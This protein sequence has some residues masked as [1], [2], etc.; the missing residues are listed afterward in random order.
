MLVPTSLTQ[1]QPLQNPLPPRD[2]VSPAV[3]VGNSMRNQSGMRR[4]SK[5][6]S[7]QCV[8]LGGAPKARIRA[9]QSIPTGRALH[10]PLLWAAMILPGAPAGLQG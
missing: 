10:W 8:L 5:T 4:V 7:L 3:H 9:A 2:S 1:L 6:A